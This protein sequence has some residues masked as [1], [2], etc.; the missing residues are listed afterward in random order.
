MINA[1]GDQLQ[2][3]IIDITV[4]KSNVILY[5]DSCNHHSYV[6]GQYLALIQDADKVSPGNVFEGWIERFFIHHP[7]GRSD[8]DL[9]EVAVKWKNISIFRQVHEYPCR[10][11][12]SGS[13]K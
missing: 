9:K 7:R 13:P 8:E 6:S 10:L 5:L 2:T 11:C 3:K 1:Y 4:S 12:C